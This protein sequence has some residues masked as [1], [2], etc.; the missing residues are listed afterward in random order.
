LQI[1]AL[2]GIKRDDQTFLAQ[3]TEIHRDMRRPKEK[4][5]EAKHEWSELTL[6]V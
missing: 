3:E 4:V 6:E 2:E 1:S 5:D